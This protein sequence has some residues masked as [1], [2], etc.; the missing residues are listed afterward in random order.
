[1]IFF[2]PPLLTIGNYRSF[3]EDRATTMATE[4]QGQE[5]QDPMSKN[6]IR[7]GL[8]ELLPTRKKIVY[9]DLVDKVVSLHETKCPRDSSEVKVRL[10]E[11]VLGDFLT[12]DVYLLA[13]NLKRRKEDEFQRGKFELLGVV[14]LYDLETYACQ[15]YDLKDPKVLKELLLQ[16]L[17]EELFTD[18]VYQG[19]YT[20]FW[21]WFRMES[22]RKNPNEREFLDR[23]DTSLYELKTYLFTLY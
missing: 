9:Q 5:Q 22:K 19:V 2:C 6:A 14:F 3:F 23:L 18:E 15:I 8:K 12:W 4:Q 13:I 17:G 7:K 11:E 20:L 21:N 1:M 16:I 10:I